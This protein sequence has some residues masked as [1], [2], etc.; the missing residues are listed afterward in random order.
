MALTDSVLMCP[1]THFDVRYAINP[2][3]RQ[4]AGV[5]RRNAHRQWSALKQ[6]I[7]AHAHVDLIDSVPG[8]P[9][10]CFT[11]NAGFAHGDTFVCSRFRH[12]ERRG[13]EA[14]FM[15]WFEAKGFTCRRLAN[16]VIFEGAGDALTDRSGRIWIGHGQR[17][18]FESAQ[19]LGE[20][21]GAEVIPLR[22]VDP[23]FYHL[24]TCFAPLANGSVLYYAGAFDA[25]SI[26]AIERR[27]ASP[28]RLVVSEADATK[29]A[30]NLIDLG[31][32]VILNTAGD[33]VQHMLERSGLAVHQLDLGEFLKSGGSAKCLVLPLPASAN[34]SIPHAH[35]GFEFEEAVQP[36]A[37]ASSV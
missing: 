36:S 16:D 10:M 32:T 1:P 28:F 14:H 35:R 11:A 22:L 23:R 33:A 6:L 37:T 24:D 29:F 31:D 27:F 9:D 18:S 3:M 19:A 26:A 25:A 12:P 5:S 7:S 17:S 4:G 13:E 21:V 34:V 15:R 8:L 30:C 20:L 2:W